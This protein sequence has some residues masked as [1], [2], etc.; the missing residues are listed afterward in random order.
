[1]HTCLRS[2]CRTTGLLVLSALVAS[3]GPSFPVTPREPGV[4]APLTGECD[5]LDETRCLLPWPSS[6]FLRADASTATGV[7]VE[8]SVASI[9]PN[10]DVGEWSADGFSRVTS[11]LAGF[12]VALD[13]DSL[14]GPLGASTGGA[15]RLFVA[16]PGHPHYGEEVP[17]RLE[18]VAES[19]MEGTW[20]L[21]GD[22]LAIL[23]PATDYVAVVTDSLHAADATSQIA[24]SRGTLVALG[25][26]PPASEAEARLAGY[27]APSVTLLD[28]VGVDPTSVLRVW[29]FSTRSEADPGRFML[30]IRDASLA[31]L[32]AGD[33]EVVID[34]VTHRDTGLVATVV[35]GRLTGLPAYVDAEHDFVLGAD[36]LPSVIGVDEA[37]FRVVIPRGTGD[38]R[39]VI[40]GHGAGG[41]VGDS[42]FDTELAET[43][44]GKVNV[45]FAGWTDDELLTTVTAIGDGVLRGARR[46]IVPL[47]QSIAQAVVIERSL[48]GALGEALAADTLGGEPN[49]H[50]GRHPGLDGPIWVGG[51]LGGITGLVAASIDENIHYAVLNVPACGWSHWVSDSL[52]FQLSIARVRRSNGGDVNAAIVSAMS[53]TLL[54]EVDGATFGP[55]GIADGDVFLVQE[56]MGDEVV[57]NAGSEFLGIVTQATQVGAVLAPIHGLPHEAVETVG[58]SGITQFVSEGEGVGDVHGF[59]NNQ[60]APSGRAAF[61]QIELFLRTAWD[62]G[63]PVVRVPS[64]CEG[65]SCDF[66]H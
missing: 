23:D 65:G 12:S 42:S 51:S 34:S 24:P 59:A 43:G 38:Y 47:I 14:G 60:D 19:R 58:H 30:A 56:S 13:A 8:A 15:M 26:E 50:V 63:A 16:T 27:H 54:D 39:V 61:E 37:P 4:R 44:V 31:A 20:A 57:P 18:I 10:D 6:T 66:R 33:V 49:P 9:N 21:V 45:E 22:P 11:V 36:G 2:V 46:A 62:D 41:T 28:D 53:Q 5:P 29:D 7:R 52:F 1:M 17:L 55:M 64:L 35:R 48:G 40:F 32:E 25:L 3:C